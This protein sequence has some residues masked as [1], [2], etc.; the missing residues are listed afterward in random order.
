MINKILENYVDKNPKILILG[1]NNADID[2][3]VGNILFIDKEY[4]KKRKIIYSENQNLDITYMT[5]HQAKGLEYDEVIVINLE[6]K[7]DG[8][9][10]KMEDDPI[11]HLV[12]E[13]DDV[14]FDE[15]RRLFYVALTRSKNNVYLLAPS[16]S[17]SIFVKELLSDCGAQQEDLLYRIRNKDL[18]YDTDFFQ[19]L[20]YFYTDIECPECHE[21]VITIILNNNSYGGKKTKYVRCSKKCGYDGGPYPAS[22]DDVDYVEKCPECRGVLVKHGDILKC[23]L[24]YHEGCTATKELKLN[25]KDLEF[26][27]D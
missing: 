11:L 14:N 12:N 27:Y 5:A 19:S 25:K 6:D 18:Y 8:F 15:E 26:D 22:L 4:N 7:F 10:N 16:S 3:Y 21:G 17:T 20:V 23:C 13:S 2:D 24:N 9:P 1:R